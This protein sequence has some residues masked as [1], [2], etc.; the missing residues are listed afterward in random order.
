MKNKL[1]FLCLL[2][3][4]S[5][6]FTAHSQ[7]GDWSD[8]YNSTYTVEDSLN[9][10]KEYYADLQHWIFIV[11]EEPVVDM[12]IDTS[13]DNA[14]LKHGYFSW[15]N[16]YMCIPKSSNHKYIPCITVIV[17]YKSQ[18]LPIEGKD[19]SHFQMIRNAI[20]P[21][22]TKFP[23][24]M[25]SK[26][27]IQEYANLNSSLPVAYFGPE[28]LSMIEQSH[29]RNRLDTLSNEKKITFW[30]DIR[31]L[32]SRNVWHGKQ[33]ADDICTVAAGSIGSALKKYYEYYT[34]NFDFI[35]AGDNRFNTAE[36]NDYFM[37]NHNTFL[38]YQHY[39]TSMSFWGQYEGGDVAIMVFPTH[40]EYVDLQSCLKD[41]S[42]KV[43]I[44]P[45]FVDEDCYDIVRN[46]N[47]NDLQKN[48][49][50]IL[51]KGSVLYDYYVQ[52]FYLNWD[53]FTFFR[54]NKR[55]CEGSGK[56]QYQY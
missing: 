49:I 39:N 20:F 37:L 8:E 10:S 27:I 31:D 28:E 26:A 47:E 35:D 25:S 6:P 40:T 42:Y 12:G 14:G 32:W 5:S 30:S 33:N 51:K 9:L 3:A 53:V 48:I 52:N 55:R 46:E 13:Y 43:T 2:A 11:E 34:D 54:Y 50:P 4:L 24:E 22:A 16:T 29:L 21:F 23:K 7:Y 41:T 38:P 17:D 45:E 56:S 44:F 18:R 19:K 1:F 36:E 15:D